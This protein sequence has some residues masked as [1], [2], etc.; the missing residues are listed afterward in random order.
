MQKEKKY[1]D[2]SVTHTHTCVCIYMYVIYTLVMS[3]CTYC[4]FFYK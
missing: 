4:Y 3:H 2:D 1:K